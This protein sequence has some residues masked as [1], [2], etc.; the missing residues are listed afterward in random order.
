MQNVIKQNSGENR[1]LLKFSSIFANNK[2]S[3][4]KTKKD[5]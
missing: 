3:R 5:V 1:I 2:H 4:S